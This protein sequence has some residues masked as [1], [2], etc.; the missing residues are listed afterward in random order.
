MSAGLLQLEKTLQI[1][2]NGEEIEHSFEETSDET[3][4]DLEIIAAALESDLGTEEEEGSEELTDRERGERIIDVLIPPCEW[5]DQDGTTWIQRVSRAGPTRTAVIQLWEQLDLK[6]KERQARS[7]GIC[8][9]R[10]G[11]YKECYDELIRQV[12]LDC[13]ERGLLLSSIKN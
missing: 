5:Q 9:I 4:D 1:A 8:A 2:E 13:P 3:A 10:R 11:L 6:T 7:R 12:T